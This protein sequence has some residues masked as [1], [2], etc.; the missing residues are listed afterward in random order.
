[1]TSL[2]RVELI[3][4]YGQPR[5]YPAA[6]ALRL[7]GQRN[8]IHPRDVVAFTYRDQAAADAWQTANWENHQHPWLGSIPAEDTGVIGVIDLRAALTRT[9]HPL[10]D[11]ALPDNWPIGDPT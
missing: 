9:G 1:M 6:R 10:T 4:R 5:L 3:D 7:L 11:P 2:N 8:H